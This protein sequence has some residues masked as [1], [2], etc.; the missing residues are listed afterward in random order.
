[1]AFRDWF[2]LFQNSIFV[3]SFD[4][5]GLTLTREAST[6][7]E[8]HHLRWD[9]ITLVVTYLQ[10]CFAV[11][12]VRL[13]FLSEDGTAFV[14][15][16]EFVGFKNLVVSLPDHLAGITDGWYERVIAVPFDPTI[17]TIYKR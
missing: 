14:V 15:T 6:I 9:E 3:I 8:S 17:H 4:R 12:Q 13:K 5:E 11:D 7:L 1:M 2:K 16:E 10:D